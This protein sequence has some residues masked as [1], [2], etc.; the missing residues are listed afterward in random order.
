MGRL[1]ECDDSVLIVVDAQ[2]GFFGSADADVIR[3][4]AWLVGIAAALGVPIVVT[5]E[6]PD[7]NGSTDDRVSEAL[8][9]ATP[10][11]TKSVFGL[12]DVA[13]ILGAVD[14]TGRRTAVLVGAETDVCVAHSALGLL[15]RGFRVA[16]VADATYSPG[17]MHGHGLRRIAEAGGVVTH[18][19]GVY[20]EWLRTV[21]AADSFTNAHPELAEPPGFSL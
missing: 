9:P 12:A 8:P 13:D 3:R 2:P 7:R 4:V 6:E 17:S 20:Y 18:A 19:K 5:E 15:D 11:L 21:E 10:V 16:V 1:L 14:A